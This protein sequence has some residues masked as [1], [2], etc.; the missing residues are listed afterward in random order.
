MQYWNSFDNFYNK[1]KECKQYDTKRSVKRYYENKDNLSNQRKIFCGKSTDVLLQKS[2]L[3]QQNKKYERKIK[4]QEIE[5]LNRRL[6][7]LTQAI[8]MLRTPN[9]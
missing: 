4:K 3:N 8:E 2:K 7:D 9:S 5:E 1:Y 6:E